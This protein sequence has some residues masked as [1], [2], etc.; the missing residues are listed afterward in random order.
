M[1]ISKF[2]GWFEDKCKTKGCKILVQNGMN[3]YIKGG[4][5]A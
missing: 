4:D 3:H 2:K 5:D 1:D